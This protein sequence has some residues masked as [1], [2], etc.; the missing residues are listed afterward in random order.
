MPSHLL[1][2]LYA[3]SAR[4]A[5][6]SSMRWHSFAGKWSNWIAYS[7]ATDW[8]TAWTRTRH[9]MQYRFASYLAGTLRRRRQ[10][11]LAPDKFSWNCDKHASQRRNYHAD[12]GTYH[13]HHRVRVASEGRRV[14]A[15]PCPRSTARLQRSP[16]GRVESFRSWSSHLF[17]GRPWTSHMPKYRDASTG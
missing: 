9:D 13:H 14:V 17:R 11:Q 4:V 1:H 8:P 2:F 7:V 16:I 5:S 3:A 12:R 10:R 6:S 15:P